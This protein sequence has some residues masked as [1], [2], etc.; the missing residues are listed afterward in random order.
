MENPVKPLKPERGNSARAVPVPTGAAAGRQPSLRT[1]SLGGEADDSAAPPTLQFSQLF[2]AAMPTTGPPPPPGNT[3]THTVLG[4]HAEPARRAGPPRR[5]A[6]GL[7]LSPG[8]SDSK[9]RM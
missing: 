5:A 9:H 8:E 4:S 2:L 6:R 7:A 1:A 3:H